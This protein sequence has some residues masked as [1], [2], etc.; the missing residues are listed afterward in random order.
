M[1]TTSGRGDRGRW[2]RAL[3]LLAS[4][5]LL[6]AFVSGLP[7]A[8]LPEAGHDDGWFWKR[9]ASIASGHWMGGYDHSTLSKGPAYPMFLALA[10]LAGLSVMTAQAIVYAGACLLL[11]IAVVRSGARPWLGSAMV[12]AIQ[13]HPAVFAWT[14]VL[15]DNIVAA[16]LL[17][18]LACLVL[19]LDAASAGRRGW[20]W[21]AAAGLLGGW[22]WSTREDGIW[23]VPGLALL[24][25]AWLAGCWRDQAALRRV[26]VGTGL[27][28]LV[29][30]G[31][32][33]LV[34]AANLAKYDSF[35]VA[36]TRDSA[37]ADALSALQ[38][39]RVGE[40]TPQVPVPRRVREAIYAASPAF[41][42][43]RPEFED[44]G[45]AFW[46][47][48]S[49]EVYA[50]ACGDYAG[51]W[52]MWALRDAVQ[53]TGGYATA[54]D[55]DAFYRQ[56]AGEIDAACARGVLTC[57]PGMGLLPPI[58]AGQWRTL[59]AHLRDAAVILAWQ[60]NGPGP[61]ASAVDAPG[62]VPM[63]TFLGRPMLPDPAHALARGGVPV[64]AE[65]AA[66]LRRMRHG[67]GTGYGI[68]LPWLALAGLG[69]FAWAAFDALRRRRLSPLL[70]IAA[71]AW[72][73]TV[74]RAVMLALVDMSAFPAI[75][76]NYLQPAFPL[77]VVAA[78][79][80]IA[81]LRVGDRGGSA[82]PPRE[83][84]SRHARSVGR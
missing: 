30:A 69:A 34:A 10:H 35:V 53:N 40:P 31:W 6:V 12:V 38:R 61:S 79:A 1:S 54:D 3:L 76:L 73:L 72:G 49:C 50:H 33:S 48:P 2:L 83:A 59:P 66:A 44:G 24:L 56:V 37:F 16:Q 18:M 5:L 29:F 62:F 21:A 58:A 67:I 14:R 15:R 82:P 11:G 77:L 7:V 80:S 19:F 64:A 17:G 84:G 20:G 81:A 23:I 4:S 70:A 27:S 36:D 47:E 43:L 55:A 68:V 42:R 46:Q 57:A 78:F 51:G 65:A 52:F 9:A 45:V 32:L 28:C 71:C 22:F 63:W 41:S 74:S 26:A 8:L 60:R 25:V 75:N 13:W 39:V